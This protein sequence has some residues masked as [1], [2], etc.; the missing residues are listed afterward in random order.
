MPWTRG[1]LG[2][3]PIRASRMSAA[4]RARRKAT[5]TLR[6]SEFQRES[7]TF[8]ASEYKS[9][10]THHQ[11][12]PHKDDAKKSRKLKRKKGLLRS[13]E[14]NHFPNLYRG[15]E[16]AAAQ[17]RLLSTKPRTTATAGEECWSGY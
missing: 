17:P 6:A 1:C 13:E 2:V 10:D 4:S 11:M 9:G 16:E 8:S 14:T 15:G 12:T 5:G 3:R 7:H